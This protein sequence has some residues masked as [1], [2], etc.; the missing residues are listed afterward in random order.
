M[1]QLA[2]SVWAEFTDRRACSSAIAFDEAERGWG[3]L[4]GLVL[5]IVDACIRWSLDGIGIVPDGEWFPDQ[6]YEDRQIL[7]SQKATRAE[8]ENIAG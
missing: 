1:G 6:P 8:K 2:N 3:R 5:C 7:R 4:R